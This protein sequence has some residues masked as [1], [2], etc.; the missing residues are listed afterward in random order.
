MVAHTYKTD[1]KTEASKM[2]HPRTHTYTNKNTHMSA[3]R[4]RS[5]TREKQHFVKIRVGAWDDLGEVRTA[6]R[7]TAAPSPRP[8]N[9][10]ALA[11]PTEMPPVKKR[12]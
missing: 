4:R 7:R 10:K 2:I 9:P 11:K 8:G 12:T 3:L 1:W 5:P 6:D